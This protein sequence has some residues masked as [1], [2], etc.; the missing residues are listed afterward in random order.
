MTETYDL[1]ALIIEVD[2]ELIEEGVVPDARPMAAYLRISQRLYPGSSGI[3]QHDPLYHRVTQIYDELYRPSDLWMPFMHT[4]AFMFRDVFFP[5]NIPSAHGLNVCITLDDCIADITDS[6]KQWLF[7]DHPSGAAFFDQ[8]IDLLDFVYGLDD[9]RSRRNL[10]EKTLEWWCLAKQHLEAAAATV[11][12]AY[13][14]YSVIQNC[15]ISTELLLKGALIE[16]GIDECTLRNKKQGYGHNLENLVKKTAEQ[17]PN[18]DRERLLSVV[19]KLPD[20]VESRYEDKALSRSDLGLIL[21]NTQYVSGEVLRQFSNR[22]TRKGFPPG[23][24]GKWNL[25][26]RTFPPI[27]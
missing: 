3:C 7:S 17:L 9:A 6:Q 14:K 22:N 1:T 2:R 25:S 15:C 18:L 12:R 5:I 27:T 26:S 23:Q 20:Y 13:N 10:K 24:Q 8:V 16:K 19:N 4:G 21:M 11:L